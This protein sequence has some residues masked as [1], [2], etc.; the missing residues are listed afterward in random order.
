MIGIP[1][2]GPD[3]DMCIEGTYQCVA[4]S[5]TCSDKTGDNVEVCDGIDNDCDGVTDEGCQP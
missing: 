5:Q 3:S 2:D 4:G 1:C